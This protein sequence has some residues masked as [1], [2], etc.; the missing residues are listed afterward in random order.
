[1]SLKSNTYVCINNN[2]NDMNAED[3]K[4]EIKCI[5]MDFEINKITL[6]EAVNQILESQPK[7]L[8]NEDIEDE[9]M[10]Y[11]HSL[12]ESNPNSNESDFRN[13]YDAFVAGASIKPKL[14]RNLPETY[15]KLIRSS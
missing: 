11:I 12:M 7:Q 4:N 5:L 9:A 15:P 8:S 6:Q 1:M 13:D 10:K 14:T 2:N 3:Y